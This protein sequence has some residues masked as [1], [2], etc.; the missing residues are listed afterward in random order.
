[1]ISKKSWTE[2]NSRAFEIAPLRRGFFISFKM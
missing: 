1:L 2:I